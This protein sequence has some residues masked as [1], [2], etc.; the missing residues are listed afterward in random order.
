MTTSRRN[1]MR[2]FEFLA[3]ALL[4]GVFTGLI[5]LI[6]TRDLT[7]SFVWL[8]VAFIVMLVTSATVVLVFRPHA[9][10]AREAADQTEGTSDTTPSSTES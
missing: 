2:P 9:D 6:S 8:G 7:V 1:R 5:V 3:L 10:L 4:V